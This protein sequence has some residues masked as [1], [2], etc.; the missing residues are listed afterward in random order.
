MIFWSNG[1]RPLHVQFYVWDSSKIH[2]SIQQTPPSFW[3]LFSLLFY[4]EGL[5]NSQSERNATNAVNVIMVS[6][7]CYHLK[8]QL[9]P[10]PNPQGRMDDTLD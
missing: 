10:L 3:P 9:S 6:L 5:K 7:Y 4:P 8:Y 1:K 2:N